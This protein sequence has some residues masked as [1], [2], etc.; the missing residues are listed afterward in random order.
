MAGASAGAFFETL[1]VGEIDLILEADGKLHPI[2][3][4][5]SA[6]PGKRVG[7]GG[8]VCCAAEYL[9]LDAENS[10]VPWWMV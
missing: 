4:K 3:I 2:E 1:V 8:V 5:K 7:P 9:P 10:I 6:Y